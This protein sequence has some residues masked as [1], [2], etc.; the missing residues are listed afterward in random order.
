MKP[1]HLHGEPVAEARTRIGEIKLINWRL[2]DLRTQQAGWRLR[3]ERLPCRHCGECCCV[4]A[5]S[6]Q[7]S[8]DKL[9]AEK[10][11]L[12]RWLKENAPTYCRRL[13]Y[14]KSWRV[15]SDGV[16]STHPI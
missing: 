14:V 3:S 7:P 1:V 8:I 13:E 9:E 2:W 5:D 11:K 4:N 15:T 10:D 16:M 12:L 6:M